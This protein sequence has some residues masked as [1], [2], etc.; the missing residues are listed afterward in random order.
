MTCPA[1]RPVLCLV[2]WWSPPRRDQAPYNRG[3]NIGICGILILPAMCRRSWVLTAWQVPAVRCDQ[4][5]DRIGPRACGL[6]CAGV[7]RLGGDGQRGCDDQ[8]ADPGDVVDAVGGHD[9]PAD[10]GTG[11]DADV[12]GA[13]GQRAGGL[14]GCRERCGRGSSGRSARCRTRPPPHTSRVITAPERVWPVMVIA[15]S[16]AASRASPPA[17]QGRASGRRW[18]RR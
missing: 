12:D 2:S 14:G 13:R 16:V 8:A 10:C 11:R 7:Q 5:F 17:G 18:V 9:L 3:R 15:D 6:V 4:M 1:S